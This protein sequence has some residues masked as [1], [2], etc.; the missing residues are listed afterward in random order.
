M[1]KISKPVFFIVFAVIA[2]FSL[3]TVFG[4][5]SQY[6]DIV[7]T[8][9]HGVD[10]IRLGIDIKGGV[11]VTF[12]P[13]DGVDATEEQMDAALET[14][15]Y[16]LI[17]QNINDSETYVDYN[18]NRIIVRF[19]WQAGEANFDPEAAVKE[20]GE[21]AEL[22][23]RYGQETTADENGNAVPAGEVILT[24]ADVEKAGVGATKDET[25]GAAEYLVTLKLSESGT[26][27]FHNATSALYSENGVIS[28]WMDNTMISAPTVNSVITNGECTI[29]GSF[30]YESAKELADKINSGALPFSL[31]TSSF[32]TISPTMGQGALEAM[33]LAG[34]ITLAFIV[35]YMIF[36]Y[37]LQGFVASVC[38][39]GQVA[40]M[41]AAVSGWFGFMESATLTIPGIA[42]IILSVGMGVDANIIT[43]ER[44]R[45]ELRAGKNVQT[46][47]TSGYKRAFSAIFD[48][49]L[50]G[51]I[52]AIVL[53]GAF[54]VSDSWC[55]QLL[56]PLFRWF[57]ATTEGVIYSFGY[58]LM[59]G[60]IMNFIMGVL[61]SR[62]MTMSLAKFKC[63][64]NKKLY[65]GGVD[66]K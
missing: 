63:F 54:G 25:T 60:L 65:G 66:V 62:L 27:A 49:N 16:R 64:Q 61:A 28:I 35:V 20:L 3:S 52:V 31:E 53:M 15:K 13:A 37:R 51:I 19:P 8:Y 2:L 10:D 30:T 9:V 22:S 18:S 44:I 59:T 11:D 39:I 12:E 23:F 48:G 41:L 6:G 26:E 45:E 1:N 56:S 43:G 14:I 50:T 57:G 47:L 7:T 5:H 29:E 34:I 40:G 24:G 33:V 21:M 17:T 46:A 4:V 32:K 55:A 42:G 36:F 38:L 58:T